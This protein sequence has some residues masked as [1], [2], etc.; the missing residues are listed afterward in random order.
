MNKYNKANFLSGLAPVDWMQLFSDL[1]F[2]QNRM[3]NFFHEMFES[4]INSYA[5]IKK[6]K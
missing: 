5:A 1:N 2:D 6:R 3:P 4:A